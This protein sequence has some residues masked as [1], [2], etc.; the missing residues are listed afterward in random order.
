LPMAA[1][2]ISLRRI[3]FEGTC[4][5]P[6]GQFDHSLNLTWI[7]SLPEQY[8]SFGSLQF[9]AQTA[10]ACL[11]TEPL[12]FAVISNIDLHIYW[13]LN[14][15]IQCYGNRKI[16]QQC[17]LDDNSGNP[18]AL[19][20]TKY[21]SPGTDAHVLEPY[22]KHVV[23]TDNYTFALFTRC[24]Y[25]LQSYYLVTPTPYVS[26][27]AVTASL[28]KIVEL[29]FDPALFKKVLNNEQ[30]CYRHPQNKVGY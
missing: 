11:G 7:T 24:A 17:A 5:D 19:C 21:A 30:L 29:G 13:D 27:H 6:P 12:T 14:A 16:V 28:L 23:L 10:E 8:V 22:K 3:A 20:E 15:T 4:K 9:W 1:M 25:G 26:P 18:Y 2:G